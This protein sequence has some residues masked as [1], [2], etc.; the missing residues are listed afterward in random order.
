MNE[1]LRGLD[2]ARSTPD[3]DVPV[4]FFL[5]RYDR[6]ADSLIAAA[7]FEKLRAPVKQLVWFESS[8]H[9]I[10]FEE[11]GTFNATLTRVAGRIVH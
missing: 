11:A 3:I 9:N 8:A 1:E 7:Y 10:P 4:V 5:G 6:H 2:L